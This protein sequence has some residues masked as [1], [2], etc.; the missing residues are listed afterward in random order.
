MMTGLH[1]ARPVQVSWAMNV[2]EHVAKRFVIIISYTVGIAPRRY[3]GLIAPIIISVMIQDDGCIPSEYM[4]PKCAMLWQHASQVAAAPPVSCPG[5]R[6]GSR[7]DV[8]Q[9]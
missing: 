4:P 1:I 3:E 9:I 7:S 6:N 8:H 5:N 2:Q